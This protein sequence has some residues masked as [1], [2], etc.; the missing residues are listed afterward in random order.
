M[1]RNLV[2]FVFGENMASFVRLGNDLLQ[3]L[4]NGEKASLCMENVSFPAVAR[5]LDQV[6]EGLT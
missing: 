5:S 2:V 6:F 4:L 1:N 3:C